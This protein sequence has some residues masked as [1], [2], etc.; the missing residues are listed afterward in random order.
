M[1]ILALIKKHKS[2]KKAILLIILLMVGQRGMSVT[3]P[4]GRGRLTVRGIDR[5]AFR[6]QYSEDDLLSLPELI[7]TSKDTVEM[8]QKIDV[9]KKVFILPIGCSLTVDCELLSL[10]ASDSDGRT[11]FRATEHILSR[12]KADGTDCYEATLVAE[13]PI[14]EHLYG[15]G[16]F[17]DGHTNVR[18]LSRRLTQVNTQISIPMYLSSKG[19][20]L[21]WNNYGMTEFNPPSERVQLVR[22]GSSSG[23]E[24]VS[25]TTTEGGRE[26]RRESNRF[27]GEIDV[28]EDGIYSLLLDVGRVMARRQE[29]YVDGKKVVDAHNT[30]LPPTASVLVYLKSGHHVISAVLEKDDH[31]VVYYSAVG[32]HTTLRSPVSSSVDYTLF[33][34]SADESIASYR[35]VSGA[36]PLMPKW[37]LGYIHCR[38]RFHNQ[39]ELLNT[40][41]RFREEGIPIDVIVQDW[42]WWGQNGWNSME[43]DSSLYPSPKQMVDKLHGMGMRL[44]LSVWSKID[45]NSELGRQMLDNGYYIKG[46]DWID[47]FNPDASRAYWDNFSRR[48]LQPYGIDCWWQD[49]TE[50]EN[51]DLV[52]RRVNGGKEAGEIYR[53][54]YPLLVNKTVYEG[55]RHDCPERRSMILTRSGF[56]GIQ[57]Y[58]AAMW[59]GDVGN[60]YPTLRHQIQGGLG[61]QSCGLPWW[62]YDAGG[63]FRPSNQYND[64]EYI[65]RML[66]W[67]ELS[68]YLPLMRVHGYM[69]NTEPWNYGEEAHRIITDCIRERYQLMPYI[70]SYAAKVTHEGGTLMR[71][72]VF[73]FADDPEALDQECEYMFGESLLVNPVT[74]AGQTSWTTY[75]PINEGGWWDFRSGEHY[76]G[77]QRI[78]TKVDKSLIPVFARGGSIIPLGMP[79]QSTNESQL[80]SITLLIYPG[81]DVHFSLYEDEELNYNY[82]QGKYSVIDFFW[83]DSSGTLTIGKRKGGY[84]GMLKKRT[85]ILRYVDGKER[86]VDYSGKEIRISRY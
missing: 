49:A 11:V 76:D 85:F 73:D 46:S 86:C 28:A 23:V 59:S 41:R 14:D 21:L 20:A 3:F 74:E 5:N 53:N 62:T 30:W 7:Y 31:P 57:R 47:F 54:V 34:G 77:G 58:S 66:R 33:I 40:A 80:D 9:G 38:E 44:M 13:S 55:F 48:L 65:E 24:T 50:P 60:D 52:G 19:Y 42:Q 45:K 32:E 8:R 36:A 29:L 1:D 82:E 35:R 2:M 6:I 79:V 75:L 16:Q 67:I 83:N 61:I 71:P 25:V 63:F 4:F 81:R 43:F 51:D 22:D 39:E 69:S 56:P 78:S 70:Y 72:L 37:A 27:S 64:P 15:L 84:R 12:S 26:E 18:G 10:E 17:Q 68:V